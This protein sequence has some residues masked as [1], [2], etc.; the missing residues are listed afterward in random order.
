MLLHLIHRT[1]FLYAGEAR[2][3]FNEVR[4]RPVDDGTQACRSFALRVSPDAVVSDYHDFH[5]NAVHYFEILEGHQSLVIEAESEV[6]TVADAGRQIVPLVS[7]AELAAS[8]EREMQAEFCSDSHYVPLAPELW[9]G[10]QDALAAGRADVWGDVIR[11]AGHVHGTFAYRPGVTGIA[12]LATDALA[13]RAGVCQDFA[14][15][16]LGLCRCIGIPARYVSG[17]FLNED[18]KPGE[19]EA[20][21]AWMEAYIPGFGWAAYDPT[22]ARLV[23]ERYVKV[24]VGRDYADIR[25]VSGTYRG[26]RTR[27]LRVEVEVRQARA[28]AAPA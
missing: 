10:A 3:S 26:A 21:H 20:S 19:S 14:H 2:N 22:H 15:V 17:Y 6:E 16:T 28:I 18:R 8:P 11:I 23:D 13:L 27:E 12:T 24:A 7:P 9:R 4:L 1:T 25:P 5:G